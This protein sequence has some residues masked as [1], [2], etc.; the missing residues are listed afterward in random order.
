MQPQPQLI[1]AEPPQIETKPSTPAE[2]YEVEIFSTDLEVEVIRRK[3][4][5]QQEKAEK[6]IQL[7]MRRRR[8]LV[9]ALATERERGGGWTPMNGRQY[10]QVTGETL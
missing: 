4:E 3:L 6:D 9:K 8:A 5:K 10:D 1:T 2:E 7:L